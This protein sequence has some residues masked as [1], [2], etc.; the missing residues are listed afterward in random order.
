MASPKCPR[1]APRRLENT[2]SRFSGS[3]DSAQPKSMVCLRAARSRK[4][5]NMQLSVTTLSGWRMPPRSSTCS[6]TNQRDQDFDNA[7][8]RYRT[9]RKHLAC[10]VEPPDKAQRDDLSH[11]RGARRHLQRGGE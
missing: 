7:G 10:P 6:E 8:D 9:L 5:G 3:S 1:S 11:V 2:T 4:L